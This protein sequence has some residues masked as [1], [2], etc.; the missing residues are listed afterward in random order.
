MLRACVIDFQ[1]GWNMYLPL[2]EFSYNKSFH[3][4]IG[5]APYEALYGCK[6]RSLI[7]WDRIGERKFLGPELVQRTGEAVGNIRK[8]ILTTQ[9]R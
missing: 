2:I 8:R 1:K 6:Y 7:Y 3:S 4:S 9:S 5:M